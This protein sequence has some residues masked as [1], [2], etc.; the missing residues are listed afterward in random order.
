MAYQT[1]YASSEP[2]RAS[3]DALPGVTVV[4]FGAP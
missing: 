4:E 3:L 1:A 2:S